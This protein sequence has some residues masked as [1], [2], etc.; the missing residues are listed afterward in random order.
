M[1]TPTQIEDIE[2]EIINDFIPELY[3]RKYSSE[4]V[5]GEY[6]IRTDADDF[7]TVPG[8]C[9]IPSKVVKD[10]VTGNFETIIEEFLQKAGKKTSIS[11][12]ATSE[13]LKDRESFV[14]FLYDKLDEIEEYLWTSDFYEEF[15]NEYFAEYGEQDDSYYGPEDD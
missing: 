2:Y 6:A 5:S 9:V 7:Y 8:K 15:C 3:D 12:L 13:N 11:E 14:D 4:T 1:L 10:F